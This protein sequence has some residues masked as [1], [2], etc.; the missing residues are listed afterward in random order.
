MLLVITS[1]RFISVSGQPWR[2]KDF[3]TREAVIE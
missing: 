3:H 1:D 2:K